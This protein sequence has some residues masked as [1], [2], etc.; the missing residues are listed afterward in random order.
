MLALVDTADFNK[1]N[2]H[3][4]CVSASG[5]AVRR[6]KNVAPGKRGPIIFMHR[7]ILGFASDDP[8]KGDH[9]N[10]HRLDNR[11]ANLREATSMQNSYNQGLRSNNST[12]HKGVFL[13]K[14]GD[15]ALDNTMKSER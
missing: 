15:Y 8:R 2:A 12:G 14:K 10:T 4:W 6:D 7:A 5:Y 11:R 1:I 9:R 13:E 3:K